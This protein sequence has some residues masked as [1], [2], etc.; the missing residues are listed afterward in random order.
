[1]TRSSLL[2]FALAASLAL[3]GCSKK[4]APPPKKVE[5]KVDKKAP[6]PEKPGELL[7]RA[8]LAME[9][10]PAG[11]LATLRRFAVAIKGKAEAHRL[12]A[13][14]AWT[15]LVTINRTRLDA[16]EKAKMLKP[17][18]EPEK[19]KEPIPSPPPPPAPTLGLITEA[20]LVSGRVRRALF[21]GDGGGVV[22]MERKGGLCVH[23]PTGG[24]R[25]CLPRRRR[26]V[27]YLSLDASRNG[28]WLM[29]RG[30]NA[31]R[32]WDLTSGRIR[33]VAVELDELAALSPD[34]GTL[35]LSTY[36]GEL[37]LRST[38]AAEELR[39][40]SERHPGP[41]A[42]E[43]YAITYSPGGTRLVTV[44]KDGSAQLWDAATLKLVG[45]V[46]M[47]GL[48]PPDLPK[49]TVDDAQMVVGER[50]G[51]VAFWDAGK[52]TLNRRMPRAHAAR[53]TALAFSPDGVLM[54]SAGAEKQVKLWDLKTRKPLS[55]GLTTPA[56]ACA[57]LVFSRDGHALRCLTAEGHVTSWDL[58]PAAP[59]AMIELIDEM[60]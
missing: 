46:M 55:L 27:A 2:L 34:G 33:G 37:M 7:A 38:A 28:R 47:A 49:F 52:A 9:R 14:D 12:E 30:G 11:A 41:R 5:P 1:M 36:D 60:N 16:A 23:E 59:A 40:S 4:A 53:V 44:R 56:G 29:V 31:A 15:M 50:S 17:S 45:R 51:R 48:Q 19:A 32:V 18:P 10:D 22:L 24:S 3:P 8:R 13:L 21:T 20:D 39:R 35:A 58:R 57:D 54:A 6:P 25:R 42:Q 26:R 43:V